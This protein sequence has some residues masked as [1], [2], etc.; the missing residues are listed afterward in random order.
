MYTFSERSLKELVGVDPA[1]V[2]LVGLTLRRSDVDFV[3]IDGIRS[4]E[5]QVELVRKGAS[6]T[7]DSKHLIGQ[8]VDLAPYINGKVR[9]E[10]ESCCMIASAMQYCSEKLNIGIRWG[11]VWDKKLHEL[12]DNLMLE[13]S[14]YTARRRRAGRTAFIDAVHF[15]LSYD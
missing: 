6:H 11:G 15:E 4:R 14:E 9:W 5:E 1:L 10:V 12:G 7:L 2:G 3:I 8:A 13:I